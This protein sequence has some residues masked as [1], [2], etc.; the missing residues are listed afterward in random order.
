RSGDPALRNDEEAERLFLI[1]LFAN[2]GDVSWR[3]ANELAWMWAR[4]GERLDEAKDMVENALASAPPD[5][6]ETPGVFDTAALVALRGGDAA[7]ALEYEEKA[8]EASPDF[9]PFHDR[10]GD[11][12]AALGRTAEARAAW[13]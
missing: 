8:I 6:P 7:A 5:D 11:I 3:A 13:E 9:A 10:L 4:S 2:D 1:A 12:Y